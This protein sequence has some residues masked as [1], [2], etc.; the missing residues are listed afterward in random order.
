VYRAWSPGA[1]GAARPAPPGGLT[2]TMITVT[3]GWGF[4]VMDLP[5]ALLFFRACSSIET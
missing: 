3:I 5:T 4:F 2:L 1:H